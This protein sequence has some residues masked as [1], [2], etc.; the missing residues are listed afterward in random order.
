MFKNKSYRDY[1]NSV[2]SYGEIQDYDILYFDTTKKNDSSI[3]KDINNGE[4]LFERQ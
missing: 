1:V 4:V 2:V 3:M